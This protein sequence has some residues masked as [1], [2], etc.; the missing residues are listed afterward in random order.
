M[1]FHTIRFYAQLLLTDLT[2]LVILDMLFKKKDLNINQIMVTYNIYTCDIPKLMEA[3]NV[4]RP[5]LKS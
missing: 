3:M 5:V 4:L 2:M 1:V